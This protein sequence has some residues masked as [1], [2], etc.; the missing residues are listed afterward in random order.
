MKIAVIADIHG[1]A[2]A[3]EAVPDDIARQGIREIVNLGDHLSGPID[4]A[5]TAE[6]LMAR[7]IPSIRGNHDRALV[8]LDPAD[9]ILTDRFTHAVLSDKHFA[10]LASLPPTRSQG[11]LFLC[12]GT[13][14]SDTTY[15][16][17]DV[18]PEGLVHRSDRAR[19]ETLAAGIASPIL[20]CGHTH[21]PRLVTLGD[22]RLVLNPGSVGCPAYGDD[23]PVPH[24]VETGSPSASYAI[25]D[26]S[27]SDTS[28]PRQ[29]DV[30]F[31]SI[32]YDHAAA[33]QLAEVHGRPD[34]AAALRSGWV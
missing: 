2:P 17:E 19:I 29:W 12:H 15:W 21:I 13:P 11:P 30:T 14:E 18:S 24:R 5:R 26:L 8:T 27:S 20:L 6:L 25:L 31:R 1:N 3:L 28:P 22:G 10:W 33:A 32:A 34:W 16:L 4:P 7:D 9:M 23:A